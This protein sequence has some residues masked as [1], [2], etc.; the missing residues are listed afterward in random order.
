MSSEKADCSARLLSHLRKFFHIA[1]RRDFDKIES[2]RE[3]GDDTISDLVV[4][5]DERCLGAERGDDEVGCGVEFVAPEASH[6]EGLVAEVFAEDLEEAPVEA[7]DARCAPAQ[8]HYG[9]A[10]IL[11]LVV[12][13]HDHFAV[14]NTF[15]GQPFDLVELVSGGVSGRENRERSGAQELRVSVEEEHCWWI[16]IECFYELGIAGVGDD[17]PADS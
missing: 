5:S 2:L 16:G 10:L 6:A 8:R 12:S 3:T 15:L 14:E 13:G 7:E 9:T 17:G 1:A 11:G 4:D